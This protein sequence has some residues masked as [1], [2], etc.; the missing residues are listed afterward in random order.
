MRVFEDW[1]FEL[2]DDG[3]SLLSDEVRGAHDQL[4]NVETGLAG[5]VSETVPVKLP[6]GAMDRAL[7]QYL[8]GRG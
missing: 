6:H 5:V 3:A 1:T 8:R 7:A 4:R 2:T